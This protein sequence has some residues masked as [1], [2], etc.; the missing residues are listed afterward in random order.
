MGALKVL[1]A[2]VG[3]WVLLTIFFLCIAVLMGS[4][5]GLHP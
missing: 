3:L 4:D 2:F 1:A 5:L